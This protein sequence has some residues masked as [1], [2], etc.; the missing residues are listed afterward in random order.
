[1]H[2]SVR[3]LSFLPTFIYGESKRMW[4]RT[5]WV[6]VLALLGSFLTAIT[7]ASTATAAQKPSA[8]KA[9]T[10]C[11][12]SSASD[13][14]TATMLA[15]K[16]HKVVSITAD[17]S[18]YTQVSA[19]ANGTRTY[20]SSA[21]PRWVRQS[22]SWVS[23]NADLVPN[24]DGSLSPKAAE[25]GLRFSGGGN[26]AL[27]T[28]ASSQ[29]SMTVTWPTALPTP[30]VSGAT[31]TYADVLPGVNLV[32]TAETTGGFE[33]SVVV[34][35]AAAA[36]DPGLAKLVLGMSLSKGLTSSADKS[37]NL[38]VEN[39]K[40]KAVFTS[41]APRAWDSSKHAKPVAVPVSYKAGKATMTPPA[42]L[43]DGEGAVFP[44]IIDP[45]YTV[46]QAWEGYDETQSVYP[47]TTELNA[48]NN[49]DV[50]VGYDGAG[51]DRGYY[52]FGLPSAADGSTTD[53]ISATVALTA[54]TTYSSSSE[55]HNL[56][57]YY[58]SQVSSTTD[59]DS[60]PTNTAGPEAV[61]FTTTSTTPNQAVSVNVAPWVQTDLDAYG[62]QF[63]LGL[64]NTDEA[65]T[66]GFVEFGPSPTL[67]ITYDQAPYTPGNLALSAQNYAINGSL[68]TSS[69]TPTFSAWSTD[70][71]G[72]QV[73]YEFKLEKGSTV[74]SD[75]TTGY[76]ASGVDASS[77]STVTLTDDTTYELYVRAYDGT[78][79]SAWTTPFTFIT[80]K[81]TPPA[82]SV[83]CSGY[84]SGAWTALISGGTTCSISD[85]SAYVEGYSYTLENGSGS[86]T[87]SWI[88]GSS[89][90]ISIDPTTDG[91]YTLSVEP[92]D[93]ASVYGTSAAYVFG[94]GTTGA[95][96]SPSDG[97]QTASSVTLQAAAPGTYTSATFE[98]RLGTTGSF[99]SI[100]NHVTVNSCGCAVTW[101]VSTGTNSAGVQTGA[102]T[103][104]LNR[105]IADDGL[106]QVEAVF[107]NS[108]GGTLTTPA[109]S[110]TLS[111][112]GSGA[113]FGTTS[114]GP[115][116]VGLQSGNAALAAT[117]VSVSSYG[118]YL[119]AG[120]TFNSVNPS[121]SGIFGPGWVPS[122]GSTQA[123]SW[124]SVTDDTSYAVLTGGDGSTYTFTE[125]STSGSTVSYTADASALS[126]GLTLT[127]NTSSN[128]FELVDSANDITTFGYSTANADYAPS[129]ITSPGSTS[130]T[131]IVYNSAG[132]PLLVVAPDAASSEAPTTACPSPASSS[133]WTA[134]C[135]GLAF[136]YNSSGDV[137][138]VDFVYVD[139]SGTYHDTPVAKYGYDTS[140]RL[141]SEWDPR[142]S[143]PLVTGYTYDETS[144]DAD[145][146]R[147]TA[148]SPAQASG[149]SALASWHFTYDDTATDVNYGKILTVARTHSSTY[150]GGTATNTIDYQVP[151]TTSAGGPV[152]MDATTVAS[153]AEADVPTSAVAIWPGGY[154]PS[155][156]TSPTA[157]DYE[158][159]TIDYFD[160][161]GRQVNTA[162]YVGGAWAVSTTQYDGNGNV[163]STLTA[164]D[165]AT[166]LNAAST[167]AE[168][169]ALSTINEYACDDFGTIGTCTSADQA[170]EVETDTYSPAHSVNVDG[171]LETARDHTAYTYDAGAPNSD[172][173]ANG[174][175][176]Q[177][178]TSETASASVGST[179]PGTSTA[180]SRTIQY[181][182][183]NG[184]DDTGWTLGAP[185]QTITD[186]SGLDVAST[187]AYN[188]NSALYN[189]DDLVT[190]QDQ[191]SDPSGAA[192]GDTHSVYY[193]AGA[194]SQVAACGDKPEWANL[195]CETY[196]AA[197][198][199]DTSTIPTTT[200]T[201]NDYLSTLTETKAYG[202]TGTE[203]I[204]YTY[205][206]DD[207][208]TGKA[209]TVSGTGMG[210][211]P[212][213]TAE[214]YSA[215]T[216]V[217]TGT[218]SLNSSGSVTS[219]I[220]TAYD[221]FG[222]LV[223]YTDA[224]NETTTYAY[225]LNGQATTRSTPYDTETITYSPGGQAVSE[226]DSLVGTFTATYNP[227]AT[228]T[229]TT[230]PDG[231]VGTYSI[232]ATGTATQLVYS[233]SNWAGPITDSITLNAQGDWATESV[234]NDS[235]VSSYDTADRL[236]SVQDTDAGSCTTR[237][238]G[239]DADSNRSSLATYAAASSGGCQSTTAASSETY[240][241][242]TADRLQ[243][244]TTAGT[245][246]TY[247]Y[248]T[249]GD[250][251]TTPSVDAGGSGNLTA[252]YFANGMLD[253]QTQG[254]TTDTYTL[255]ATLDR[256]ATEANS[257]TG[258]TTVNDYSGA[259]DTPTWSTTNGA[260]TADI[261]GLDGKLDAQ[262]T[263]AGTTTL[264]LA[265]LH[266]D[267]VAT[268]NPSSDAAPSATY[269][270]T[271]F[272]TTE[273]GSASTSYG[274]LGASEIA[275]GLGNTLL[276]G[277]RGYNT[278]LGRF[279]ATDPVFEGSANAYD[280]GSQNPL[281]HTD[282][283]G[284]AWCSWVGCIN[285]NWSGFKIGMNWT[286]FQEF[287]EDD[288]G[289]VAVFAAGMCA[290]LTVGS[291]LCGIIV[292][293]IG[294]VIVNHIN[295]WQSW[296]KACWWSFSWGIHWSYW[297]WPY[298]YIHYLGHT[299]YY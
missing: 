183:A 174:N 216:G 272:G 218:E 170:Y 81:A 87:W 229:T 9:A 168:A 104:Y 137:S 258:Y 141:T 126:A 191:P 150:G 119:T 169:E 18:P 286:Q 255:D 72:N 288:W 32:V 290:L 125:G 193:T 271:E 117:D 42:A 21:A 289:I 248:D 175:P 14:T 23:V 127:K 140:G 54:V 162:S 78:E 291:W 16:C 29:G 110:V 59:W 90:S 190:D 264:E 270:Y 244:S 77:A 1:M 294:V 130:S 143:T 160:A 4:R 79:Y 135:R 111:R 205:D 293:V 171:T 199:S 122:V 214:V 232:D 240:A 124:A 71:L 49:G 224:N 151:L 172:K 204:A 123:S 47:T 84:S 43:L 86:S 250:I 233:N 186:P 102:L 217:P 163:T 251:T 223:S 245:T 165:R 268:V 296:F 112:T 259:G 292:G 70:P 195:V 206:T 64:I 249:Q 51:I 58:T 30:S 131:G 181:T 243:S 17:Q 184:S 221:D 278:G 99:T 39:A 207:R 37:G 63:S 215:N 152:N 273:S 256:Y 192:A 201:Y 46:T 287:E 267:I 194:N 76:Y 176:Y 242:D 55:A 236:T 129:T 202:S 25:S 157:T 254:T 85:S 26:T 36:K 208:Q 189:G 103:W 247:A 19:N 246:S 177:L 57:A 22:G 173:D 75:N 285:A 198:P 188:E 257:A 35:N 279:D 69:L 220:A 178:T 159:A 261:T 276:M 31:A 252:S 109:V 33:E 128:V 101:P 299:D 149:S 145:Y 92:L 161:N 154:T 225:D 116:S 200:Y 180:D 156:T 40:G 262:V 196:Q 106:V 113:D 228:L 13:A 238:Y 231:T 167:A 280:Y 34:E 45:S 134:G 298:P 283:S 48:T 138:E 65:D 275:P 266:G 274:Y 80:D 213:N 107:T 20:T 260:W 282:I 98:Y 56:N 5:V 136:D 38:T 100:P 227:D 28:A 68:Y 24:K 297:G 12:A 7:F 15:K 120:R 11:S 82:P 166:A 93:D 118:A 295:N 97:S 10:S 164:A 182:Y 94:V 67:S 105:T 139:N 8:A 89:G 187:T 73:A 50:S 230:L 284:D 237:A 212:A 144:T 60:A 96:L 91:L 133:T 158:Y 88:S 52:V 197:Q 44:I 155:S 211:A 234:L 269:A 263:Q 277:A 253:T 62:W 121:A 179:V 142:L 210:T 148:Y 115:V 83:S 108:S 53:V 235:K 226:H 6:A 153:W 203:T 41:P 95:L 147:I 241:Y 265:D 132:D 74:L 61:D 66:G 222:Q 114:A 3:R 281:A 27:A 185:F 219:D 146:G 2:A 209:I 239:Y